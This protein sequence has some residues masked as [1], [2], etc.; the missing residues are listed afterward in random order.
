MEVETEP[1]VHEQ[2]EEYVKQ[3]EYKQS[4]DI[5]AE[6]DNEKNADLISRLI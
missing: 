2:C 5:F 3:V 6:V 1:Y 4:D